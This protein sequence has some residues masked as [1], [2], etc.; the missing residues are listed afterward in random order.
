MRGLDGQTADYLRQAIT[1]QGI[2]IAGTISAGSIAI[3]EFPTAAAL[4]DT[5]ANP[6]TTSVG[7]MGMVYNGSTWTR[8]KDDTQFGDSITSGIAAMALRAYD[9]TDYDRVRSDGSGNL[10]TR[11]QFAPVYE[12]NTLGKAVVE[13]R[14]SYSRKTADGQVKA[15][16]GFIHTVTIAPLTAT[17]TAGL[18]TIYDDPAESGTAVY[19]E[20]IFATDVGHT[21][22]L[23]VS[24]A[25]GIYVG[26]D[27][28]LANVGVTVAYR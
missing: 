16:A 22:T 3:D 24:C 28:A 1:A 7:A 12:D 14:Y 5:F 23:D 19:A 9:G 25:N 10:K 6:T 20:W 4:S 11:E 2:R 18:L 13:H 21:I 15:S 26:F 17:P 27:G 8:L